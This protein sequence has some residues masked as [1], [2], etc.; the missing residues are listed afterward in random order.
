M[1]P[2]PEIWCPACGATFPDFIVAREHM[3]TC[4]REAKP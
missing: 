4:G 3:L 1:T 2:A